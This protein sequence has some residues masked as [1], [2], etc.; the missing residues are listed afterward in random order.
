MDVCVRLFLLFRLSKF[1]ADSHVP[2]QISYYHGTTNLAKKYT[3]ARWSLN[4]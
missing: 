2:P 4:E 1:R 3:K